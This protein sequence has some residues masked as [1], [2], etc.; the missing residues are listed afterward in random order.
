[1]EFKN[2]D[3]IFNERDKKKEISNIKNK[4]VFDLDYKPDKILIRD[5][6]KK[7]IDDFIDYAK[8]G[9][10]QNII[11]YGSK[12]SGKTLSAFLTAKG[13]DDNYSIPFYYVNA[14]ETPTDIRIYGYV[15]GVK[16]R[17]LSLDDVR[18]KFDKKLKGKA[19]I[20]IDEADF[21]KSPDVLYHIT[22][23]TGAN[24]MLLTQKPLWYKNMDDESVKSSMQPDQIF[25]RDYNADEMREILLMRASDGLKHYG[26]GAISLLA[27]NI[28]LNYKSDTRIGIKALEIIGMTDDWSETSM[29]NAITQAYLEIEGETLNNLSDRDLIILS[30]LMN[31]PDT[32]K[33]YNLVRNMGDFSV[34][35]ISK[36]TFFSSV[37]NLQNLGLINLIR[38]KVNRFY[39][40]ETQILL[41]DESIVMEKLKNRI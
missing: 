8:L 31:E 17:G 40:M 9:I 14:R 4:L 28:V 7:V 10:K 11:I 34:N 1:M 37:N 21:L 29:K 12:G 2:I 22:R 39:T 30:T 36:S 35:G 33:A 26:N 6:L 25:F 13:L 5:E 18:G 32:S 15:S 27:A 24:L 16:I 20:I 3:K 41:S 38:K 23:Y 19:L